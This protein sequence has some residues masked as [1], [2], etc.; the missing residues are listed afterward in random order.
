MHQTGHVLAREFVFSDTNDPPAQ[1]AQ[2]PVGQPVVRPVALDLGFPAGRAGFRPSSV[3]GA[4][5]R[6]DGGLALG[7]RLLQLFRSVDFYTS[8]GCLKGLV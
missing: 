7:F 3:P 6:F 8:T 4:A 1:S 5:L 2:L